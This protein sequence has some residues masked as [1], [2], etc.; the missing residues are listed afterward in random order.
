MAEGIN[1]TRIIKEEAEQLG[2]YMPLVCALY[3]TMFNQRPV[4]EVLS[5]L[6]LAE[7]NSDVEFTV[8][9]DL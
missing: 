8:T 4:N 9:K 5:T 1:T 3:E 6:M 7:Q 2:I